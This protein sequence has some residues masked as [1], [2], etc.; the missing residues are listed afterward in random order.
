MSM[1]VTQN[2]I[3]FFLDST[4]DDLSLLN[5]EFYFKIMVNGKTFDFYCRSVSE[6]EAIK[7]WA[8]FLKILD[9]SQDVAFF[10]A[11]STNLFHIITS[12]D[13][14]YVTW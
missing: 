3:M 2:E 11:V 10:V 8:K 14:L 7:I 12:L 9:I 5:L 4:F 6:K 13:I 1:L